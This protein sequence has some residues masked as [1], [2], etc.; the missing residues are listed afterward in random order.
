MERYRGYEFEY[1]GTVI[2]SRERR[3]KIEESVRAFLDYVD[4]PSRDAQSVPST[5]VDR[6]YIREVESGLEWDECTAYERGLEASMERDSREEGI[7]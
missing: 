1:R 4:D 5:Y 2:L 7:R 3:E 6:F